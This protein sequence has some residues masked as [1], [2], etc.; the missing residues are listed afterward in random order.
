MKDKILVALSTFAQYGKVPLTL[1]QKSNIEYFLNPS[2][3]RLVKEEIIKMGSTATGIIAGVEPYDENV[4][5]E[6]PNLKCISRAGVGIDNIDLEYAES[7][8]IIIRNT[9]DV[10]IRPVAE[11]TLAMILDLLRKTTFHTI[12][13]K[14]H[15]WEKRA[16]NLLFGKTVGIIG[17]GRIGKAVAELLNKIDVKIMACDVNPTDEWAVQNNIKYVSFDKLLSSADIISL[18]ASPVSDQLPLIGKNEIM[19]MKKGAILINTSR[20]ECIDEQALCDGLSTGQVGSAGLD[21]FPEEP[22]GGRLI[23]FD[24]VV[25]TPHIATLTKESRLQMEIEATKNLL[26]CLIQY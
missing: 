8:N 5:G 13:L 11:L 1:L 6:L 7:R 16:G 4:L 12:L 10:V 15:R 2:G 19:L 20:G 18:H 9:P 22:Y 24:N 3:R 21:V 26:A 17:T 14:N 23:E 25:L